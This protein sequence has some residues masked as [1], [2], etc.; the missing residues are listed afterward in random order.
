MLCVCVNSFSR[1]QRKDQSIIPTTLPSNTLDKQHPIATSNPYIMVQHGGV[2][3]P[4]IA[5]SSSPSSKKRLLERGNNQASSSTLNSG[6]SATQDSYNKRQQDV[7]S[8]GSSN[9]QLSSL[10]SS[11]QGYQTSR[12]SLGFRRQ[13]VI[14]PSISSSEATTET[15]ELSTSFLHPQVDEVN[16][17]VNHK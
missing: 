13:K 3:P 8:S 12:D 2:G 4:S 16:V 17:T 9:I 7:L 10:Q 1:H 15:T 11:Q 14:N 6:G 5:S